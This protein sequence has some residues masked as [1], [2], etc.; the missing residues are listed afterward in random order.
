MV[1]YKNQW[2]AKF[3][4]DCDIKLAKEEQLPMFRMDGSILLQIKNRIIRSMMAS[5]VNLRGN[6]I[7]RSQ[8]AVHEEHIKQM[9]YPYIIHPFSTVRKNW[10]IIMLVTFL[11]VFL[12]IPLDVASYAFPLKNNLNQWTHWKCFRFICD[13]TCFLDV[14]VNFFTGY[15]DDK[16]HIIEMDPKKIASHYARTFFLPDFFSSLPSHVELLV[17]TE[18]DETSISMEGIFH[19]CS[20]L[21]VF[22]VATFTNYCR[23]FSMEMKINFI[24]YQASMSVLCY[25]LFFHILACFGMIFVGLS[26]VH[27]KVY[28]TN[29]DYW[30]YYVVW[31]QVNS[32]RVIDF[33]EGYLLMLRQ[34]SY[35]GTFA[36]LDDFVD[37]SLPH[38]YIFLVW[39]IAKLVFFYY[40]GRLMQVLAISRSSSKKYQ[41]MLRELK[42]YMMHKQLPMSLQSRLMQYYEFRFQRSYFKEVEIL[43]TVSGQL[44]QDLQIHSCR[45]IVER[46]EFFKAMPMGLIMQIVS[47]LQTEI[48]MVNDVVVKAKSPGTCMFFISSGCVA[49]YTRNGVELKTHHRSK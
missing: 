14:F 34:S 33:S 42:E 43:R 8:K 13:M 37:A 39:C 22:R 30:S 28:N 7:L 6:R 41:E 9:K 2:F 32:T 40:I 26:G 46:V 25:L 44:K 4:H 11:T 10:E 16:N 3:G 20:L 36:Y 27:H 35:I 12:T 23:R 21:K 17:Y 24:T 15:V 47:A 29:Y 31:P 1:N 5:E 38:W 19:Y 49:C 45:M 48:Y 18:R